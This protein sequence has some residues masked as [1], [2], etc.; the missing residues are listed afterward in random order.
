MK[1]DGR[2]HCGS[3]RFEAEVDPAKVVICHCTDCQTL[4]GSAFRTVVPA[5]EGTFRLLA[6]RL[7]RY[8][9]TGESGN[10]REQTFCPDCGTPVYSA[11]VGPQPKVV[12]LPVGAIRQR[13][14]LV[15][16]DQYWSRSAQAWLRT[17]ADIPARET[18]PAFGARGEIGL[19]P[20]E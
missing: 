20:A 8:V 2:C 16:S 13:D 7:K 12:A 15:P 4:S 1:V 10:E 19:G 3:V 6:G 18:Q 11:P 9:K 14:A 5:A 17:L